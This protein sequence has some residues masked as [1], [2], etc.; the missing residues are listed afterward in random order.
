MLYVCEQFKSI[1][2]ESTY[3]GLPCSFVRLA[4]CNLSC[5]Y[6]DTRYAAGAG[7]SVTTGAVLSVVKGHGCGLVE[8][9][10]GEPLLQ[11]ETPALCSR[12]LDGGYTV[13]VET[14]G[15]L[16]ISLLPEGCVRIVDVKCPLSGAADSFRAENLAVLTP[17]DQLKF[18]ISGRPDF[19]WARDFVTTRKLSGRCEVI[20]SPA[21][22]SVAPADLA[23]WILQTN[24]PVRM[25][26][27]LHHVIWGDD[28]RGR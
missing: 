7:T 27:Q 10:G 25:G 11:E 3:A 15:S 2:G 26:L 12:L 22:K 21:H 1:Q 16:D 4:G 9:T 6:C 8:V 18:V 24:S 5:S 14:N 13:L 20:F 19:D 28:A 23:Q 17:R